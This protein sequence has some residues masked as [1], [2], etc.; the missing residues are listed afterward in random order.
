MGNH[1]KETKQTTHHPQSKTL[2]VD[3]VMFDATD[4][5]YLMNKHFLDVCINLDMGPYIEEAVPFVCGSEQAQRLHRFLPTI[6]RE[7]AYTLN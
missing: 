1:K 4:I 3:G 7:V 6:E 2:F 5:A